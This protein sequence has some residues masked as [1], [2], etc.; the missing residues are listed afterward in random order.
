MFFFS[1]P[2][3]SHPN[4]VYSREML[5]KI[6]WGE[7]FPGD[8]RTV[9]VHVRRLREKVETNPSEP[10]YVYTKWGAGYYFHD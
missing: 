1:L 9:D 7:D 5:L 6:I 4:T 2:N 10:K 3:G 8:V